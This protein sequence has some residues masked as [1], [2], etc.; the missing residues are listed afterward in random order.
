MTRNVAWLLLLATIAVPA[1][2]GSNSGSVSGYVK[3]SAGV[4]QMGAVVELFTTGTTPAATLFTD[5]SGFFSASSL[6]AGIYHVKVTAPSF[7]PVLRENVNIRTGANMVVNVTLNTLY[8]AIQLAPARRQPGQDQDDW[9]WALRTMG[10]RPILR[11]LDDGP[12]VVSKSEG[13]NDKILRARVAFIAGSEAEGSGGAAG[14]TVFDL[15]TS[16][17][18]SGTLDLNG[19]LAYNGESSPASV[20]RA[21]YKRDLPNGSKAEL[22]MTARRFALPFDGTLPT[23]MQAIAFSAS[24]DFT[25]FDFAEVKLGSEYQSIQMF[26]REDAVKP[27][28]NVDLHLGPDTILAYGYATTQPT[29]REAKGFDT[30]PA[31]LSESGPR[32]SMINFNPMLERARHQ[33][34]SLTRHAGSKTTLG[35]AVFSDSISNPAINGVGEPDTTGGAFLPDLYAGTFTYTGRSFRSNGLRV[36]AQRKVLN[37]L[38]TTVDYSYGGTL[39]LPANSAVD[40]AHDSMQ[41]VKRHTIGCK[42]AGNI[43]VTHTRWIASYRWSSGPALVP[44]DS[45]NA[46]VGQMDPYMN[47]FVRQP[48]PSWGFLPKM[49]ALVDVRNLLAQ[50]YTPVIGSDGRMMYLVQT[51]RAV[52]GGVS[53]SF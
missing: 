11:I 45:F 9:K 51:A 21:T 19:N 18:S 49:E 10:N 53:F 4:P 23:A 50:G 5:P 8:E 3:N 41:Q 35:A 24:D 31:D 36:L 20:V 42:V 15:E 30:A 22:S 16:M 34:V 27:F 29:M 38:T 28:G 52:R 6:A 26:E 14:N 48:M 33:E 32:M 37:D 17:F 44:I 39:D 46:S 12:V 47:I 7:L 43:P 2:A 40:A 1:F 13:D 25:L